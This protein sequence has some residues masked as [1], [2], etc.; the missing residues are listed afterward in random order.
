MVNT[1]NY[2]QK[3]ER[4]LDEIV[5][6]LETI[7]IQDPENSANWIATPEGVDVG[8]AD[9][10]LVADQVEDWDE[11]RS[12]IA[13]LKTRYNNLKRAL[14]KIESNTYGLCEIS[15]KPIEKE[16]LEANPAARTNQANREEEP[17]L[18]L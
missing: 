15:D 12:T 9:P 7:G 17:R 2:K 18:P 13:A 11:R 14:K 16:R 6:E 8:K 3:L 10:N 1:D 4:L 5:T